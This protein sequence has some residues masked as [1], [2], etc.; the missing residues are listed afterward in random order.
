MAIVKYGQTWWGEQWLRSLDKIDFD[1]RLP[2]GRSY[3]NKG[4]VKEVKID[5]T[6]ISAKVQGSR[7]SPYKISITVPPFNEREKELLVKRIS[8]NPVLISRLLNLELDSAILPI[9]ESLGIKVFPQQW[10]DFDMDCSCPDWAVPCKHLAAVIYKLCNEIDNNP[11]LVFTLHGVD[12]IKSLQKNNIIMGEAPETRFLS[13]PDVL[14]VN[15]GRKGKTVRKRIKDRDTTEEKVEK[16]FMQL[17]YGSIDNILEPLVQILPDIPPFYG[18]GNFRELYEKQLKNVSRNVQNI[19][20][21]KKDFDDEVDNHTFNKKNPKEEFS[22]QFGDEIVLTCDENYHWHI[23]CSGKDI[24]DYQLTKAL[25]QLAPSELPD[26]DAS[27]TALYQLQLLSLNL[28]LKGAIVPQI[29]VNNKKDYL[30]RW[31]PA[32]LDKNIRALLQGAEKSLPA[33]LLRYQIGKEYLI[34]NDTALQLCSYF[35]TY[36]IL[37]WSRPDKEDKIVW[38]FF[39]AEPQPFSSFG[40]RALPAGIAAWLNRFHITHKQYVPVLKIEEAGTERFAISLEVENRSNTQELPVSLEKVMSQKSFEKLRYPILQTVTL[41]GNFI[42]GLDNYLLGGAR[43][44]II[45]N[46]QVFASFLFEMLPVIRLLDIKAIMPR[47]LQ[48]IFKPQNSVRIK[49][50]AK[51]AKGFIRFED[52]LSFEWQIALGNEFL[53]EAEFLKLIHHTHGIVKFRDQY[54]FLDPKEVERL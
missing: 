48:H 3:A 45:M 15:A 19:F 36:F 14:L 20:S 26:Y 23:S 46:P 2:R 49:A 53:D 10:N 11:F 39:K 29:F 44:S 8:E 52:L 18:H 21:G 42:S 12:L 51:A 17:N 37:S 24:T 27:V 35:I 50:K 41:L 1:N 43:H 40:E 16:A 25:Y 4:A 47:S 6:R 54:I 9:A 22:L 28:L 34:C 32:Q 5:R 38:L 33:N 30:V 31:L 7:A 13:L